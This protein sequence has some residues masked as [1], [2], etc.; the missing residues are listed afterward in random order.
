MNGEELGVVGRRPEKRVDMAKS[1]LA[2]PGRQKRALDT[3]FPLQVHI[4]HAKDRHPEEHAGTGIHGRDLWFLAVQPE[5]G[6]RRRRDLHGCT[7][8]VNRN[9]GVQRK[10]EHETA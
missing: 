4:P 9:L 6:R 8:V 2:W 7:V 5:L 3:T 1:K 10:K